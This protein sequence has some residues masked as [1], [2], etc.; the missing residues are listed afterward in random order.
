[1]SDFTTI[2][3]RGQKRY[4]D[5]YLKKRKFGRCD[6]CQWPALLIEYEDLSDPESVWKVCEACYTELINNEIK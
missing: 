1:M 6:G 2:L 5:K 3:K 4:R